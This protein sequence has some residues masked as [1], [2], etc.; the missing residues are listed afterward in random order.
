[1]ILTTPMGI[2]KYPYLTEPDV[3]FNTDGLFHTKLICKKSE[4]IKIK[5]AIDDMIAKKVKEQHDK[6]PD[7]KIK[8]SYPYTEE[9]DDIIFNFKMNAKGV[10]KFDKKPFTQEPNILNNDHTPF[11]KSQ[12]KIFGGSTLQI[13]FEPYSLNMP[14]GIGCTLRLKTV[15]VVQLITGK[16]NNS[17]GDLKPGPVVEPTVVETKEEVN[18]HAS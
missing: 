16:S 10:R 14:V 3:E 4:C 13:T 7:K 5:W 2:A 18:N 17:L 15:Q 8:K 1:M 9:G 12:H 11:D 6:D